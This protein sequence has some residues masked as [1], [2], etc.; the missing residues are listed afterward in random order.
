MCREGHNRYE[1]VD[2]KEKDG[3]R[4]PVPDARHNG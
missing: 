2:G 4:I 1:Q 3:K